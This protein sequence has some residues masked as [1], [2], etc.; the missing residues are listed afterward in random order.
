MA[1]QILLGDA[2]DSRI[3][4]KSG[5]TPDYAEFSD[6]FRGRTSARATGF[7]AVRRLFGSPPQ[8]ARLEQSPDMRW[9]LGARQRVVAAR[10]A[11]MVA[12]GSDVTILTDKPDRYVYPFLYLA[13]AQ[14]TTAAQSGGRLV[15]GVTNPM[16]SRHGSAPRAIEQLSHTVPNMAHVVDTVPMN[17]V[18]SDGWHVR[19]G[20]THTEIIAM[21]A[22][23]SSNGGE[24]FAIALEALSSE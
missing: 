16:R 13:A 8:S 7:V 12:Q 18:G 3:V 4:D 19:I 10:F 23:L 21:P 9:L 11:D 22:N 20:G 15:L 24:E 5:V 6:A 1:V 14:S 2:L 17:G